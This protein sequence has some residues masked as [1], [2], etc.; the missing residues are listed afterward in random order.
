MELG[1]LRLKK[2]KLDL[3]TTDSDYGFSCQFTDGLNIIR[4]DNSSGKSTL[5]NSIIYSIGMEELIGGQGTKSLPYTLKDHVVSPSGEKASI[6]N[7]FAYL[8]LSNAKGKSIVLKRSIKSDTKNPKLIEI[9]KGQYLS[10]PNESY[11]VQPT[12]IHDKGS[13]QNIDTGFFRYMEEFLG[14]QLPNVSSSTGGEAKLYLQCIFSALIIEQKRGWT[15][16]LANIPYFAIRESK[17]KVI[18]YIL[19]LDVFDNDRERDHLLSEIADISR[20]WSE[21]YSLLKLVSES[22]ELIVRGIPS[23]PDTSFDKQLTIVSKHYKGE[24]VVLPDYYSSL[25]SQLERLTKKSSSHDPES[26]EQL[27]RYNEAKLSLKDS[28]TLSDRLSSELSLSMSRLREHKEN[29][30]VITEDLDKNKIALKLKR[31]GAEKSLEIA[32][33]Q[34]PSCHQQIDDSLLLADTLFYPMTIEENITYLDKQKKMVNRYIAGLEVQT[35]EITTQSNSIVREIVEKKSM[36]LSL[37][38]DLQSSDSTQESDVRL[39]IQIEEALNRSKEANK[40]IAHSLDNL[41]LLVKELK[42]KKSKLSET[43]DNFVYLSV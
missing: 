34:C 32:K 9:I 26:S 42:D 37:K 36:L 23:K 39:K 19:N 43:V 18:Q 12:Y 14:I 13:A 17:L 10:E 27:K 33:D 21:E 28:I 25:I 7:S 24:D 11:E 38:R 6:L 41:A 4:G 3:Q 20:R 5:I 30:S 29:I 8:E 40:R 16:Y 2:F 1:K 31:F 22:E 15:D 35:K